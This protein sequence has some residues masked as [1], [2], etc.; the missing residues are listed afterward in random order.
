MARKK[1]EA[2]RGATVRGLFARRVKTIRQEV[3]MTGLEVGVGLHDSGFTVS[4]QSVRSWESGRSLPP[5][6]LLKPMSRVLGCVV[7]DMQPEVNEKENG[8][9][10]S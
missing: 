2:G 4:E 5:C 10:V 9:F 3:G 7:E 1:N 6:T 8:F